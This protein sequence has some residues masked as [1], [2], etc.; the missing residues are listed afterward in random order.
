MRTRQLQ[1]KVSPSEFDLIIAALR[2][3]QRTPADVI[4]DD[5]MELATEHEVAPDSG[6]IDELIERLNCGGA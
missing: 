1:L 3:W 6:A 4:G 2:L 5:L